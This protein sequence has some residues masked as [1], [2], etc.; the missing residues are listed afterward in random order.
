[1]DGAKKRSGETVARVWKKKEEEA[2]RSGRSVE[3]VRLL[4]RRKRKYDGWRK[5]ANFHRRVGSCRHR[6]SFICLLGL[7]DRLGL[8]AKH[9]EPSCSRQQDATILQRNKRCADTFANSV[10]FREPRFR[11]QSF[12]GFYYGQRRILSTNWRES[13]RTI[14]TP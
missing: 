6:E 7:T 13:V 10:L 2:E 11:E 14:D 3:R 4:K 8:I 1:M 9:D 12:D 5:H